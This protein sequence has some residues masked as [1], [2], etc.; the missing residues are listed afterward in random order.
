M[1]ITSGFY[2]SIDGDRKYDARQMSAIFDG[3]IRDGVFMSVGTAFTVAAD[4]D[5]V[6]VGVGR[7]WFNSTWLYNDAILPLTL[8]M[9]EVLLD[10]YDAV[11]IEIDHSDAVRKGDIKIVSGIPSSNPAYPTLINTLDVHQYPLAYIYR[12]KQVDTVTQADITSMIGTSSCPYVIGLL[13]IMTIDNIVAQWTAQWSEWMTNEQTEFYNWQNTEKTEF[14][15]WKE[16]E[17]TEYE[18][19]MKTIRGLVNEELATNFANQVYDLQQQIN[20]LKAHA[21]L[22]SDFVDSN[23]AQEGE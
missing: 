21:I 19:W 15:D 18:A 22:D 11:V 23:T 20:Y 17:L 16:K 12:K 6:T 13:E 14:Y 10:R 8:P 1:S 7:C 9:S 4:G 3:I 2:N 5:G